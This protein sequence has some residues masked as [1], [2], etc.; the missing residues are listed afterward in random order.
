MIEILIFK[1]LM[2]VAAV[3]IGATAGTIIGKLGRF[4]IDK[5]EERIKR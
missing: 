3:I 1:M 2:I 5:I 4:L